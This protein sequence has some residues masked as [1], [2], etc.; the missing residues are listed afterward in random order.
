MAKGRS[1]Y[2][3]IL[4]G[5]A[6]R[7]LSRRAMLSFSEDIRI[8]LKGFS[9]EG[10]SCDAPGDVILQ[11]VLLVGFKEKSL[12]ALSPQ[13]EELPIRQFDQLCARGLML[14]QVKND[15]G[16]RFDRQEGR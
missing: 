3:L 13:K 12:N 16:K 5:S 2:T 9:R 14:L 6:F 10:Q 1:W 8:L 11:Q 7:S 15:I 4:G